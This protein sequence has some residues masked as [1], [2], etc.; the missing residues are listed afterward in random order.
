MTEPHV[1]VSRD[2]IASVLFELRDIIEPGSADPN[3]ARAARMAAEM[4]EL[5]VA[6]QVMPATLTGSLA[7]SG[8]DGQADIGRLAAAIDLESERARADAEEVETWALAATDSLRSLER[9]LTAEGLTALWGRSGH[10]DAGEVVDLQRVVGGYSKD[11]YFFDTVRADGGRNPLVLRRDLPFGPAGTTVVDEYELLRAARGIG[12]AVAEPIALLSDPIVTGTPTIISRRV[13]GTSGAAPWQTDPATA[14]ALAKGL[15]AQLAHLHTA[16]LHAHAP[17]SHTGDSEDSLRGYIQYWQ[18]RWLTYRTQPS[19]T[20]EAA[21]AWLL[22]NLS[23]TPRTWSLVHGDFGLHNI[24]VGSGEVVAVLDWEFAHV[25]DPVEDLSYLRRYIE[26]LGLWDTFLHSY[27]DH[28]GP[29]YDASAARYYE[30]WRSVRNAVCC[31]TAWYGFVHGDYPALKA[32]Y[33][34]IPKYRRYVAA[35]ADRLLQE[36]R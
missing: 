16:D 20:L 25:G 26:P 5:V 32:A 15:A 30:V 36:L 7:D 35:T 9:P 10:V 6:D 22:S 3:V 19:A 21:F 14:I 18:Q 33:Q 17:A 13:S 4:L 29:V 2:V 31:A 27:R 12:L 1:A 8:I 28:G 34:G 24:M 11:T 23:P